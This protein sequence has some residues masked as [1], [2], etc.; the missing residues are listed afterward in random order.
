MFT[1]Y[2][3]RDV[4]ER[5]AWTA[6][7]AAA[8]VVTVE[9]LDAPLWLAV[10]IAGLLATVKGFLARKVGDPDSASTLRPKPDPRVEDTDNGPDPTVPQ[11]DLP[12]TPGSVYGG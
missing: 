1:G 5:T 12:Q 4:L 2:F 3:R 7:Q 8:S 10:P 6:T 9:A 11:G